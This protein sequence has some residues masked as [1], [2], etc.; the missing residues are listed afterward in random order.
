MKKKI[1]VTGETY[2]RHGDG[3][4]VSILYEGEERAV[5]EKIAEVHSYGFTDLT[6]GMDMDLAAESDIV[7]VLKKNITDHNG[8]GCDWIDV[9]E[10]QGEVMPL[11]NFSEFRIVQV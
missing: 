7:D 8:D 3:V 6:E 5:W 2:T 4:M 9:F 11:V 10:I 1:L